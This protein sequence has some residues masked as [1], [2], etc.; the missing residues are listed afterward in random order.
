MNMQGEQ[1]NGNTKKL[2]IEFVLA[3]L[4]TS[5]CNTELSYSV[6]LQSVVLVSVQ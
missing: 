5:V 6:Y 3:T 4:K 2:R 1:N